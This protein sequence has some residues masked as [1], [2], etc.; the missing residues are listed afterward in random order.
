MEE[1]KNMAAQRLCVFILTK[2]RGSSEKNICAGKSY[3]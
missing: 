3:Y 1:E 2:T